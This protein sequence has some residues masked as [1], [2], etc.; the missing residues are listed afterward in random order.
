[1]SYETQDYTNTIQRISTGY[2]GVSAADQFNVAIGQIENDLTNLAGRIASGMTKSAVVRKYAPIYS[3]VDS[4]SGVVTAGCR[5]GSLVYW[6]TESGRY[7]PALAVTLA[8]TTDNG[9][10][11]EAPSA[12]VEGL[13]LSLDR[14]GDVEGTVLGTLLIGGYWEDASV[15][16]GCIG[17]ANLGQPG[18]YY[19]SPSDPGMAT[20]ATYGH[21]RQPVLSYYGAN[22]FSLSL[23]YMA[24]DNHFHSSCELT[25]SWVSSQ[26]P[27]EGVTAPEEAQW[28]YDASGDPEYTGVGEIGAE[29]TAIFYLGVLQRSVDAF[30]ISDGYLWYKGTTPPASGTVSLFN[31]YPWAYNSPIVRTVESTNDSI[32]VR[33]KNGLIQLTGYD[34]SV[35]SAA[36][37]AYAVSAISGSSVLMTPVVSALAAGPGMNITAVS[38]G[39]MILSTADKIGYPI[40]ADLINH[41]GTAPT[42]DGKFIYMSFPKGRMSSSMVVSIPVN[43]VAST[44]T[45]HAFLWACISGPSS[46]FSVDY[47]WIQQPT[48]GATS[49]I[50]AD[51]SASTTLSGGTDYGH[52]AYCETP[53]YVEFSG[54]G[55]LSAVLTVNGTPSDTIRLLR[56]GFRLEVVSAADAVSSSTAVTDVNAILNT[57]TAGASLPKYS[58]VRINGS[59]ALMLCTSANLANANQC[60][61]VM[62][63]Q[64]SSGSSGRY[65]IQGIIQDTSFS[66]TPGAPVYISTTGTLT[67][68]D[69]SSTEN[70]AFSQQVGIALANSIVQI[71]I[72]PGIIL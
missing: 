43:G 33:N 69:P 40:D 47:Y 46:G 2:S 42:S 25:G 19:L 17:V 1:M 56:V 16:A 64:T 37:N 51:P 53:G 49:D 62:I 58:C 5:V 32:K 34:F 22:Q 28:W 72:Q 61:G 7:E 12:R 13:V 52:V 30:V 63:D 36:K 38:D 70:A 35:G 65:L 8:E 29:T 24:H 9:Q 21:L 71:S 3:V 54:S 68:D 4:G 45:L 31:H 44:T 14:P 11:I 20:R 66:F 6:N 18:T 26:T 67:Q 10:T 57:A 41:N 60:V 39:T 23:F 48:Q 59:G 27:P 15:I 55:M 50:P